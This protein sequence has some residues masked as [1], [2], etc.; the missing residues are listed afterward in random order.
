MPDG[1]AITAGAGTTVLTDD[2]GAGGHAQVVKLA[3]STDASGTLIPADATNGIDVDVTRLSALVAGSA[4]VGKVGIDQTTPGTTNAVALTAGTATNEIVGDVADGAAIAG[5]PVR[6]GVR[7]DS[8]VPPAVDDGDVVTPWATLDGAL[9]VQPSLGLVDISVTPTIDT[10]VYADG[11]RLGSVMTFTSAALAS[12]R[13]GTIVG[14]R[15]VDDAGSNFDIELWLFKASPTLVG[16]DNAAFD[17]TDANLA[18]AA[19][20]GVIDF[21]AANTKT[22]ASSSRVCQGTWLG[23]PVVLPYVTSGSTSLF[24]VLE[25]RGA[26]DAVATDDLVVT[27]TVVRD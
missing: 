10:A 21:A 26:Y 17:I 7:A 8:T 19:F 14:A 4:I 22:V 15:L 6:I 20:V 3:I 2:T 23:G 16:A 11:D 18:T 9:V 12:G 1:V 27:I 24:G 5:N 25:A 13:G